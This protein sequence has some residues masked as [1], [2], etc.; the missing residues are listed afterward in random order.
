[1]KGS[2]PMEATL[3][4]IIWW[5]FVDITCRI[6]LTKDV[7]VFFSIQTVFSKYATLVRYTL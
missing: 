7:H 2:P 6:Y 3:V 4:N 1:M 5:L